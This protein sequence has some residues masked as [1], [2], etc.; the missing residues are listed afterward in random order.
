MNK[1]KLLIVD[2]NNNFRKTLKGFLLSEPDIHMVGE[3]QDGLEAILKAR[4]LKPDL[5]LMDIKMPGINGIEATRRIKKEMPHI[6]II[7]LSIFDIA[8]Y[9]EAAIASGASGF[10]IKKS[11]VENL[12]PAV[13]HTFEI[14]DEP[15]MSTING[16]KASDSVA[17]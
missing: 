17:I 9:Q 6:T 16:Q 1:I 2:D 15:E 4:E 10:I 14:R 11:L 3:A 8:E 7:I 13:R 12:I 5:I